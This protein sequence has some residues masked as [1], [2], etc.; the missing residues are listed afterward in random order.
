M[1]PGNIERIDEFPLTANGKLDK[2]RLLEIHEK[3]EQ[4]QVAFSRAGS[5]A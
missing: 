4:E 5:G 1:V 3:S 2:N